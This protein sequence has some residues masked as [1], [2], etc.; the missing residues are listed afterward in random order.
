MNCAIDNKILQYLHQT[1]IYLNGEISSICHDAGQKP[2]YALLAWVLCEEYYPGGD[3]FTGDIS[4]GYDLARE[5]EIVI[6]IYGSDG[7]RPK[8]KLK[9]LHSALGERVNEYSTVFAST[10]VTQKVEILEEAYLVEQ[11]YWPDFSQQ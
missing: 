9:K 4:T 1:N 7:I 10:Q 5:V 8:S 11:G 3:Y 6:P 2:L